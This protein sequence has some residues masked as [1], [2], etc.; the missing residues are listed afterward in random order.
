[1]DS[2]GNLYRNLA[3]ALA[4]QEALKAQGKP[5]RSIMEVDPR[6]VTKRAQSRMKVGRNDPCPCGSGKKFKKCHLGFT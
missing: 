2:E 6:N 4:M 3:I 1:M 5:A